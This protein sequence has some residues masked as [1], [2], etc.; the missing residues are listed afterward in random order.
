[1]IRIGIILGSTRPG[2]RGEQVASWVEER[3][4]LRGD[5]EFELID[6]LDHPLPHLDELPG[7]YRH[8]HTRAWAATIARCDGFVVV[9]PEYNHSA[10]AVL[11]NALDFL[12][13]EWRDKAI[14]FVSYGGVGG[15]RAVE[16]LRLICGALEMA[17][18]TSQ[19]SLSLVTEFEDYTV[20]KPGE[21]N[22]AALDKTLDQVVAWST[23]LAALRAG[24]QEAELRQHIG[25]IV[26]GIKAKDLEALRRLYSADVVSF[27][28]QPPLQHVGVDAKLKNWAHAFT[29]FED[30]TYEVRD[31]TLTVDGS[32]AFGHCFGRLAATKDGVVMGGMWVRATFCFRKI[33]GQWLITHDQVSV[34]FDITTGAGV[35]DLEP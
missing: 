18:V 2:R 31:L 35:A 8:E 33:D 9:T 28:V 19:V 11:K 13:A 3:A 4:G 25:K 6:L 5:A 12:R 30:V 10:P 26:E 17:D 16:Q 27:D 14:G 22:V 24:P 23:A 34:P 32:V 15:T 7:E 20:F 21:Y 29:F 1:M